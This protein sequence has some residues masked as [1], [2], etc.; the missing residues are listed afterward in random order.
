MNG[1]RSLQMFRGGSRTVRP[2]VV[3][4][5]LTA[6]TAACDPSGDSSLGEETPSR[7][8][9]SGSITVPT[10]EGSPSQGTAELGVSVA[11]T[12]QGFDPH[13]I[14]VGPGEAILFSNETGEVHTVSVD[15]ENESGD[16]APGATFTLVFDEDGRHQILCNYHPV[17]EGTITVQ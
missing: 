7:T 17:H 8:V 10:P 3:L 16:I 6:A 12:E 14:T 11:I 13:D 5:G 9:L 4:A 1:K 2:L 15:G